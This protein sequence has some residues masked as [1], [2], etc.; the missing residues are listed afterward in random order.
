MTLDIAIF[1]YHG[2]QHLLPYTLDSIVKNVKDF[3]RIVLIWDGIDPPND[4]QNLKKIY[5]D[6]D[7]VRHVDICSW[8]QSIV[9]W[10]WIKQQLVKLS[11]HQ[12][13]KADY[14]WVVDSDVII[15][16][17]PQIFDKANKRPHLHYSERIKSKTTKD[18][19]FITDKFGIDKFYLNSFVGSTCLFELDVLKSML[20]ECVTRNGKSLIECVREEVEKTTLNDTDVFSEFQT[21]NTYLYNLY[22]ER[23]TIAPGPW[24]FIGKYPKKPVQIMWDNQASPDDLPKIYQK[25]MM[26][27]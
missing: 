16:G 23:Y 11:S 22:P 4:I 10:G 7:Y 5:P 20:D 8:P 21:Y 15:T 12:Y 1:S 2:H 24:S 14:V 26:H 18:Y 9:N 27:G 25:Y 3:N 19:L 13:S 6:L 17:D